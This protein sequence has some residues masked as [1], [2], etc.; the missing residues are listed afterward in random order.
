MVWLAAAPMAAV[1]VV[2]GGDQLALRNPHR[3]VASVFCVGTVAG[4]CG[5]GPEGS[6]GVSFGW[7]CER[8][9]SGQLHSSALVLGFD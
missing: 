4:L 3:F 8:G 5:H 1:A 9:S 7:R 6:F 2:G